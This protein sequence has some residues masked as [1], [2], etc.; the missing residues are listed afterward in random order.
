MKDISVIIASFKR[1][2]LLKECLDSV[3]RSKFQGGF[4]VIVVVNGSHP[5]TIEFLSNYSKKTPNIKYFTILQ[6]N[7]CLARNL[8]LEHAE[9]NIIYFIDDDVQVGQD[10]LQRLIEKFK[11]SPQIS[12]VGGPNLTPKAGSF[13]QRCSGYVF[14]SIF[15]SA[16]VR[17]RYRLLKE[18]KLVDE[19]HLILCNLAFSKELFVKEGIRFRD[20]AC[21][22][23]NL[24]LYR[25]K[26]KGYEMLYSPEIFVYHQRR[27]SLSS[28]MEQ[29]FRYGRG[30]GQMTRIH[31]LSAPWFTLL[32]SVLILYI[33]SIL[34]FHNI[35]YLI[36]FIF[37]VFLDAIFS[38]IISLRHKESGA[39]F[40]LFILFPLVHLSYGI[41]FLVGLIR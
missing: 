20:M 30:R 28:M 11:Q 21:N 4:E 41:G 29:F 16:G 31:P 6:P 17:S 7:K 39:F 12:I 34:I 27:K 33:I 25:L 1:Q 40:L 14:S 36:P 38:F 24:I 26:K 15:G 19:T 13:F 5:E 9:G 35:L 37:Y 22:E 2:E 8:A 18:D 23:E 32:P 10:N 3:L